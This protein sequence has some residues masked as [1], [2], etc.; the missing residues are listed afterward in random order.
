MNAR[1]GF[2]WVAKAMLMWPRV[3]IF[4]DIYSVFYFTAN[5]I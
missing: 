5:V 3:L 4:L 1:C 2:N